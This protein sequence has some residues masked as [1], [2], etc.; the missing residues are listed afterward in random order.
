MDVFR[1]VHWQHLGDTLI[2]NQHW[3][4]GLEPRHTCVYLAPDIASSY[5][6]LI[7]LIGQLLYSK[8]SF[9]LGG[10]GAHARHRGA[11]SL[12][13]RASLEAPFYICWVVLIFI[14][15]VLFLLCHLRV[16][17]C[18]WYSSVSLFSPRTHAPTPQLDLDLRV[19]ALRTQVL[20]QKRRQEGSCMW[21][22]VIRSCMWIQ[23]YTWCSWVND[24]P[25]A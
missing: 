10:L 13:H 25:L 8:A 11:E 22:S 12:G 18:H 14:L 6:E 21:S 17:L 9:F 5:W 3:D 19:E 20:T 24:T 7:G 4:K 23:S 16:H 2:W 15:C 1:A